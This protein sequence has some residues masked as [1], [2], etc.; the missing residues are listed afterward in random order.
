M[1]QPVGH[2]S[3][4]PFSFASSCRPFFIVGLALASPCCPFS[5]AS[6]CCL[7]LMGA[8]GSPETSHIPDFVE[9]IERLY[10][11]YRKYGVRLHR[12]EYQDSGGLSTAV[13]ILNVAL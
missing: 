4:Q 9:N 1:N 3:E 10:S 7:L 6:P 11:M 5:F 12:L 13:A 2:A 8:L